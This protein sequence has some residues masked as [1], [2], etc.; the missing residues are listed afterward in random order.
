[1][2]VEN[3]LRLIKDSEQ[4]QYYLHGSNWV[5]GESYIE[6]ARTTI[7]ILCSDLPLFSIS[8]LISN[9]LVFWGVILS[10][11]I[12]QSLDIY[13]FIVILME[14]TVWVLLFLL[15]FLLPLCSVVWFILYLSK[16][17]VQSLYSIASIEGLS[18][19]DISHI[20]CL[21]KL[22]LH[23]EMP[24]LKLTIPMLSWMIKNDLFIS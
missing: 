13:G 3:N 12:L 15:L 6:S 23:S 7:G 14:L 21:M 2:L 8:R 9:L 19:S 17:S 10:V 20:I 5:T 18:N 1:M 22:M 16:V 24:N 11:G 4:Q